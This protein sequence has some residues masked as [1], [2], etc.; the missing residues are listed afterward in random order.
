MV[1]ETHAFIFRYP[2]IQ[3]I[4]LEYLRTNI[5]NVE[6]QA[7]LPTWL[8]TLERGELPMGTGAIVASL[9]SKLALAIR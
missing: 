6:I 4:E 2:E 7:R 1:D 9:I 8:E 3:A 5:K